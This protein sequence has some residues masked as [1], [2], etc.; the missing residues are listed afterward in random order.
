[1]EIMDNDVIELLDENDHVIKFEHFVTIS[2]QIRIIYC[3]EILIM[4]YCFR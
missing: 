3:M 2:T 4:L 1:M